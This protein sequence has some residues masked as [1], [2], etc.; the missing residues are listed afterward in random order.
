[1]EKLKVLEQEDNKSTDCLTTQV[2]EIPWGG[3]G[4]QN[5]IDLCRSTIMQN[6][7]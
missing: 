2:V 7:L 4:R 6:D 5:D 1:M 3:G